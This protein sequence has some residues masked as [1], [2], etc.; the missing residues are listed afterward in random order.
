MLLALM[1]GTSEGF[2]MVLVRSFWGYAYTNNH[3]V[4]DYIATMMPMLAFSVLFDG[5]QCVL[6]GNL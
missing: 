2:A 6:S 1:V 4:A 5:L 3:E